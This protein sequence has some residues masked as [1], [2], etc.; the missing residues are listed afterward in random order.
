MNFEKTSNPVFSEG[1]LRDLANSFAGNGEMTMAGTAT[2]TL[3]LFALV[4]L[5]GSITWKLFGA[6][7]PALMPCIA[8]GGIGGFILALISCFKPDKAY[9][10]GPLYALCEGL[11][12]G[13]VSAMYNAA[14]DGIVTSAVLLTLVV[15]GVVFLCY[16]MGLLR[17]SNTFV[18]VISYATIGIGV[19][20]LVSML[21]GMFGV[22]VSLSHLGGVGIAIQLVIVGV[23]ALNLVLDFN[24]V[25]NGVQSG[26]SA[27]YEWYYAFGLMVTVV[28][29]YME[30]LRLLWLIAARRD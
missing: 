6:E 18:K 5:S 7:S 21:L 22:N 8:I 13:G 10:F 2:K 15:C 1:R 27:Q 24:N 17:A 29:I 30:I 26:F 28:W 14:Y 4:V 25:E 23:A 11:L 20:Y 3:L 9:I 16:R 19:F 12:L